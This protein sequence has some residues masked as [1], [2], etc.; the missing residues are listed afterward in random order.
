MEE[1]G[2]LIRSTGY[3]TKDEIRQLDRYC[4]DN[5]IEF[6][7]SLSTFGHLYELLEREDYKHLR[8]KKGER[9][10]PNFW[11]GRMRHHTIDPREPDSIKV[12][13]SLIDQ[14]IPLFSSDTFNIC[15]DETFD[16]KKLADEGYDV[17]KLYSDFVK[18]I[19]AH[20]KS[21][22]K[23]VMMWG[24]ILLQ[25]PEQ[26]DELPDDTCFLNWFYRLNP[27]EENVTRFAQS[28]KPQIVC[29]GTTTWNRFC[30]GVDIEENNIC[31]MAEYGH[32]HG[33]VGVLNTNWGDW[34]NPCSVELA[35][36][37]MV[38]GAEK[39]W[40][41]STPADEAFHAKVNDLLYE[42][43]NG[44]QYLR[45]LSRMQD[46]V[47][48]IPLAI[49]Y[50]HKRYGKEKVLMPVF[51][52]DIKDIQNAYLSFR[53]R[54][55]A[56]V[57][58]SAEYRAEMLLAAEGICLMAEM[59]A[60]DQDPNLVRVTDTNRWLWSFRRMWTRKNKE[61]ELRNIEEMFTYLD[62]N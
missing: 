26:I 58:F 21:R 19:I 62:N 42:N 38:L 17:G 47:K 30:E 35:M 16:L 39:S 48:W 14:Y 3:L 12:I 23:K 41:V 49:H 29:P 51:E 36:Y 45:E 6:I 43:P 20:V 54:L 59:Y 33:A 57:S 28:G 53:D 46:Q 37:G 13:K 22:G 1:Y 10:D 5:F 34:G 31:L 7:P 32:K 24:D 61:S 15:C 25:H 56:E 52:C 9:S 44:V 18:Q 4:Q 50:F 55:S 40:T 27:P 2:D 60:K 11:R 8:V